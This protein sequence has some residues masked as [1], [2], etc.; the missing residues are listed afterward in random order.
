MRNMA[1]KQDAETTKSKDDRSAFRTSITDIRD[2][3]NNLETKVSSTWALC[4]LRLVKWSKQGICIALCNELLYTRLSK[5]WM[6]MYACLNFPVAE[7][8]TLAGSHFTVPLTVGGWTDLDAVWRLTRVGPKNH[9]L[10]GIQIPKG[11]GH[12]LEVAHP[13]KSMEITTM[14]FQAAIKINNCDNGSA[15]TGGKAPTWT[16]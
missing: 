7:H 12:F 3:I 2:K 10:D 13:L 11:K 9:V 1:T 15:A 5:Y 6:S 14:G 4:G 8:R 16:V